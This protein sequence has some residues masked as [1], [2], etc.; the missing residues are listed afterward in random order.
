[1]V[2]GSVCSQSQRDG[3]RGDNERSGRRCVAGGWMGFVGDGGGDDGGRL[4]GAVELRASLVGQAASHSRVVVTE[5][6]L[7]GGLTN[8]AGADAT[9]HHAL[10]I[11]LE[12]LSTY[13]RTPSCNIA[14]YL[15]WS[16]TLSWPSRL[17]IVK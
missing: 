16:L 11:H 15:L 5:E 14:Y 1:M 13:Y 12:F 17:E 10:R 6:E 4:A 8:V 9:P 7:P 3:K 2:A